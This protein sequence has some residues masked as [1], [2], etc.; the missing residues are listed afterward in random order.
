MVKEQRNLWLLY[1]IIVFNYI[2]DYTLTWYYIVTCNRQ[3]AK[4]I[5]HCIITKLG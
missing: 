4:E 2:Y 5:I 3:G 1:K